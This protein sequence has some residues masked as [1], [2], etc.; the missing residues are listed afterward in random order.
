MSSLGGLKKNELLIIRTRKS[1]PFFFQLKRPFHFQYYINDFSINGK[2]IH[3]WYMNLYMQ[4]PQRVSYC[5]RRKRYRFPSYW[6]RAFIRTARVTFPHAL[7]D[8]YQRSL[9]T[10]PRIHYAPTLIFYPTHALSHTYTYVA[11][12]QWRASSIKVL[13]Q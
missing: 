9:P 8:L 7:K 4:P 12:A 2:T 10:L 6:M 5:I 11:L 3:I 1:I 13:I